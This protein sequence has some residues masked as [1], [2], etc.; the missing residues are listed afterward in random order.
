MPK[1]KH[2][3]KITKGQKPWWFTPTALNLFETT[4]IVLD[5]TE[6][7]ELKKRMNTKS[8]NLDMRQVENL[9]KQNKRWL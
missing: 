2:I 9:A 4:Y 8:Y 7:E 5:D 1:N 3:T 6:W